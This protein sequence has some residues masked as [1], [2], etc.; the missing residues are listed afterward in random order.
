MMY[1]NSAARMVFRERER[2]L[3]D[4]KLLIVWPLRIGSLCFWQVRDIKTS[5]QVPF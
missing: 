3:T 5:S 2:E 1:I 4:D